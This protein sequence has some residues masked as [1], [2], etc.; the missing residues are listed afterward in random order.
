MSFP[1][2]PVPAGLLFL[3]ALPA[4]ATEG[5][6]RDPALHGD[7]VVFTAEGDLWRVSTQGGLAQRLTTHPAEESQAAL[8]PDGRTLAFVASYEGAPEVYAMPLVGGAP[9]RLSFD[10]A[11]VWVQGFAPDGRVVYASE[12]AVGPSWMRVLR[13][14]DSASG[15]TETLPLA[16]A[17]EAAFDAASSR[18]YFSR[19]GLAVTNDNARD[20][21]GGAAAQLWQWQLGSEE[22]AQRL[23]PAGLGN[24]QRPLFLDGQLLL[25]GEQEGLTQ[26]W[27]WNGSEA[28]AAL[29]AHTDFDVRHP[30]A[31]GGRVVYQHGADLRL[32]DL[33]SGENRRLEI[34]L[35]S[36]FAQTRER[37]LA[38]PL[39]YL[40]GATL[41][42]DGSRAVLTARGQA[43]VAGLDSLRR[44]ELAAP[45]GARL[46][47]AVLPKDATHAYALTDIEGRSELWS[48]P[49]DGR[50][51]G[52]RVL[53]D[54][55][56]YRLRLYPSPDGRLLA[57]SDKAG[58]LFVLEL[59]SGRNREVDHG[60]FARDD[61]YAEVKWSPDSRHLAVLRVD[62]AR[63]LNQLILIDVASGRRATL[64]SDRYPTVSAAF[65][66]D[67]AFLYFLASRSYASSVPGPWG[68]RN[69]GPFFDRR[70]R[71]YAL[72]LDPE[73]RFPFAPTTELDRAAPAGEEKGKGDEKDK[74]KRPLVWEG[75]AER[76]FEAPLPAGNYSELAADEARLYFLE[77]DSVPGSQA[78][79]RT[80]AIGNA[81]P[82]P[83]TFATGLADYA[84]SADGKKLLLLRAKPDNGGASELQIV[85]AGAKAP[86]DLSRATLKLADWR[87]PNDPREEWT[88]MFDDA[89]RMHREF[90]F[91]PAMRGLDWDAIR[92]KYAALLPRVQDRIELDDLLAQMIAELG[93]LHSQIRPGEYR[94]APD[95]P[96]PAA[97]GAQ[98]G[99]DARGLFIE[100]IYRSDPELPAERSPLA[101]PGVD[102]RSGD[103]LLA[104]NGRPVTARAELAQALLNQAGQQVLLD[105]QRGAA[106]PHRTVVLPVRSDREAALRYSDWVEGRRAR[107]EGV[108]EG[109]IGYL[110]LRAMGPQDIAS[111]ARDFYAQFD[112][113][114]LIIDVRRN[115]GG[116]IDSWILEKLLRRAWAFWQPPRGAPY[117][118]MQQT[119]RGHLV[120]L[121]DALTYSDGETFAA[122]IKALQLGPVIGTR[123]AGAG[124]WLSDRNRLVDGGTARIAEF[125][126]F[127]VGSGRWL[128]EGLG[129]APDI[130]VDNPPRASFLGEDAQLEAALSHLRQRL[131]EAPLPA[132]QA[133]PIPPRGQP[134]GDIRR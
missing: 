119:F 96:V 116:N 17:R 134:A 110:H 92:G 111:F 28:P 87:L 2:L 76:L 23:R 12:A 84:L 40:Q 82:K 93:L 73:A 98:I 56:S 75:L 125:G 10:N 66:R 85:A 120:V 65:S 102:A 104:V 63:L 88:Q 4:A 48:Y 53:G 21:V 131:Q 41:A 13:L 24:P 55:G 16:D 30:S 81:P 62:S 9:K 78:Q 74:G 80:L 124:V 129:V 86:E 118:N 107:V 3:I 60:E 68:D 115:R 18:V 114:G 52:E 121:T 15:A 126:Q 35:G 42:A 31:H 109:R 27:R 90:S 83:E 67:G 5:W 108:A 50:P 38:E 70:N 14:V 106:S 57:H 47:E 91:D 100:R 97:L 46:R 37:Q 34:R 89:W 39:K 99:A 36:D 19:F 20:Y 58:R 72:A 101:Q 22:E 69:T 44:I 103:R 113:Q 26:L 95:A 112:R 11:R 130:E 1:R 64:T 133:E 79:L 7:T 77:R 51:V 127:E 122:G 71:L 128:I 43:V 61:A 49:A 117:T 132:L 32:L 105:L 45:P 25:L 94:A 123:T 54:E 6:Y 59:A 33:G 8:S 29:T